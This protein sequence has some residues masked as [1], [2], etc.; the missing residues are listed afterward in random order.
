[1]FK[2]INQVIQS[3]VNAFRGLKV[4]FSERNAKIEL[5]WWV[6]LQIVNLLTVRQIE[7]FFITSILTLGLLAFEAMNTAIEQTVNAFGER[8]QILKNAKD[9]AA[10]AT[11]LVAFVVIA[12]T[13]AI[14]LNMVG[15]IK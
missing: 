14:L 11:M 12:I 7:I 15:I 6:F 2:L 13:V 5:A 4:L 10:T 8:N 1:M 3:F 9:V